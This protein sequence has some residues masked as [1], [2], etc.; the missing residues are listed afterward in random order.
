MSSFPTQLRGLEVRNIHKFYEDRQVLNDVSLQVAPGEIVG[1]LGP[2]GAGK[3]TMM[4]ILSGLTRAKSGE[5]F[6]DGRPLD[7]DRA[8]TKR[9]IG[10]IPQENN[11]ERELTVRNALKC[12][13]MLFGVK[14][15]PERLAEVSRWISLDEVIDKPV[16]KLSGGFARRA[17]IARAL[18]PDPELLLLD[19]PSVGLDPDVRH[20]L[21]DLIRLVASQGKGVLIT[22]HYMEEAEALCD[23]V[24]F[25]QKGKVSWEGRP[26]TLKAQ[27]SGLENLFLEL[28][29][30]GG[31]S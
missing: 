16:S 5:I 10:I 4:K 14:N 25:L 19:E 27:N 3:T 18:L 13:A 7:E 8:A 30:E 6:L 23:R 21:W 29:R 31:E 28:V 1:L 11:L 17:L 9:R 12:Y 26:E 24:Y 2:T 22:T 20:Q 15:F